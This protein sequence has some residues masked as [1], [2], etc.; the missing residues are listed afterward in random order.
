MKGSSLGSQSRGDA[1]VS[2]RALGQ[3][4]GWGRWGLVLRE[5]SAPFPPRADLQPLAECCEPGA[6]WCP[7]G[8][9]SLPGPQR[10]PWGLLRTRAVEGRVK[11]EVSQPLQTLPEKGMTHTYNPETTICLQS[12]QAEF[13][14]P[15][16]PKI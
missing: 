13:S 16:R 14:A 10:G 4:A 6:Q 3:L 9:S 15:R 2:Q 5:H 8:L 1:S 12:L 7:P 11:G